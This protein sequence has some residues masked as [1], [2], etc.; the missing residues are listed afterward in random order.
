M[1]ILSVELV[2]LTEIAIFGSVALP[3]EDS[4]LL[5]TTAAPFNGYYHLIALI[6]LLVDSVVPVHLDHLSD[7]NS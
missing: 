5:R 4:L 6:V 3:S 7:L 1:V 2:T